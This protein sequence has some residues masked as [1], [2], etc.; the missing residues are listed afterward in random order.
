MAPQAPGVP[1]PGVGLGCGPRPAPLVVGA[2]SGVRREARGRPGKVGFPSRRRPDAAQPGGGESGLPRARRARTH[3]PRNPDLHN[4]RCRR[5]CGRPAYPRRRV[6]CCAHPAACGSAARPLPL[7]HLGERF[8]GCAGG[9]RPRGL[10][11]GEGEV[12][13]GA[14]GWLISLSGSEIPGCCNLLSWEPVTREGAGEA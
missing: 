4:Y 13:R 8:A 3:A 2:G 9:D 7:G 1:G 14:R 6:F 10:I 11:V 12:R 5:L